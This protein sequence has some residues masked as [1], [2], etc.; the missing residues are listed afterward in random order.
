MPAAYLDW[1]ADVFEEAQVPYTAETADYLDIALRK[2]VNAPKDDEE[3][4]Y[5]RLRD[6]WLRHGVPG[7]QLLAGFIR[8]EVFSRRDSPL[9]P[10]EGG[11]YYTNDYVAKGHPPHV[12][13]TS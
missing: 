1:L 4:V 2:L 8:D 3:V 10:R 12:H 7:R 11:A 6:R 5:R 13:R 9:R